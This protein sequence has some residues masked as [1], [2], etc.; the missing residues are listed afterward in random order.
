MSTR[1]QPPSASTTNAPR[2]SVRCP[3][4]PNASPSATAAM[5]TK[6]VPCAPYPIRPSQPT[7]GLRAVRRA[8]RRQQV[9]GDVKKSGK[10][11]K[12]VAKKM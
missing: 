2:G 10:K 7:H 11:L 1:V 8:G 9:K 6:Q 3:W 12:D 5:M 4:L